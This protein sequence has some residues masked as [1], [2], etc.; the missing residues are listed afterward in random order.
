MDEI[1]R[2]YGK[3]ADLIIEEYLKEPW[4][5]YHY[6]HPDQ[7]FLSMA[8]PEKS[9][10][11]VTRPSEASDALLLLDFKLFF[12]PPLDFPRLTLKGYIHGKNMMSSQ[13]YAKVKGKKRLRVQVACQ[14]G[15]WQEGRKIDK[16]IDIRYIHKHLLH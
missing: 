1:E 10:F 6:R 5:R 7:D 9:E 11:S 2:V 3:D 15:L 14:F 4:T 8:L 12:L 13:V 16:Q